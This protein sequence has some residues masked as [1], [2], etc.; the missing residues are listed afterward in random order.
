MLE[1]IKVAIEF[2]KLKSVI[3]LSKIQIIASFLLIFCFLLYTIINNEFFI[4]LMTQCCL[5]QT[6]NYNQPI[7]N[8]KWIDLRNKEEKFMAKYTTKVYE[9]LGHNGFRFGLF[10]MELSGNGRTLSGEYINMFWYNKDRVINYTENG[11]NKTKSAPRAEEDRYGILDNVFTFDVSPSATQSL[12]EK[13]LILVNGH[14]TAEKTSSYVASGGNSVLV[15]FDNYDIQTVY[16]VGVPVSKPHNPGNLRRPMIMMP[17]EVFEIY[18]S[19][20][21]TVDKIQSLTKQIHKE[22]EADILP[23]I[24]LDN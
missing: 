12:I 19:D 5:T 7:S 1:W 3:T 21:D 17:I 2:I 20:V 16:R 6:S 8:R 14:I 4:K 9:V 13:N 23:L 10:Y 15:A 11:V 24:N 22:Y 18:Q